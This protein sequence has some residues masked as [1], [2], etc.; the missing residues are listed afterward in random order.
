[1]LDSV[2][3]HALVTGSNRGLGLEFVRQLVDVA[4]RVFAT[5]REPEAA[6]ALGQLAES[7]R[8][9]I[10]VLP[11]DVAKPSSISAA[12][13]RVQSEVDRLD[14]LVNNAGISGGG[15]ADDFESVDQETLVKTFRV[16]AAG[17][18]IVTKSFTPLLRSASDDA[19]VV[20]ITSS[21]GSLARTGVGAWHSYRASKA[22]LNMLTRAKAEELKS[23]GIIVIA[24]HPG[25]AETDMG[26]SDARITPD[27]SVSRMLDVIAQLTLDDTSRFLD[28]RGQERAW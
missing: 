2:A 17:P 3:T 18:H 25:W 10:T 20:N 8:D 4:D 14:L 6:D 22:A 16:N 19:R 9:T 5:C 24:M 28:Y 15:S 23:H 27:E 7:N 21:L 13:E 12:A 26:G 11:L 1:M